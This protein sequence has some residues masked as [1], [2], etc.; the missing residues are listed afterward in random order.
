[1]TGFCYDY[2]MIVKEYVGS[3]KAPERFTFP[4]NV[5]SC[6]AFT[7]FER[8]VKMKKLLAIGIVLV[9]AAVF[10]QSDVGSIITAATTTFAAVATLCVTIGIFMVG[11]RLARKVR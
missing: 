9:P 7:I 8:K 4:D 6:Q 10:A 5:F 2:S 1:M 11:Y 3:C